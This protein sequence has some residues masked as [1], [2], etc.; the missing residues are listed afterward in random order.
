MP[1]PNAESHDALPDFGTKW[2][3]DVVGIGVVGCGN[4]SPIYLQNLSLF[5]GTKVVAVTDL[6]AAKAK[7]R[8]EE[9][10]VPVRDSVEDLVSD[11]SVEIVLNLTVPKVHFQVAALAVSAGK[12][13]YNEKPLT[14]EW[15]DGQSLVQQAKQQGVLIGCAPDTFLGAGIQTCREIVDSGRIGVPVAVQA[16]MLCPG[17]ESWHPDPGFYYEKGGGPL[18]DMGPYYLT[19]LVAL[20]GPIRTV[21]GMARASF[22]TRTITSEP[23]RGTSIT[24]ETPTNLSTVLEFGSGAIG[25]LSTSFDVPAHTLPH[26]EIYGSEGTLQVP[27]PNGFGGTPKLWTKSTGAWEDIEIVRPYSENSRGV[28]VLD[29]AQAAQNGRSARASGNLALHVLE[30]MHAAHWAAERREHVTLTTTVDRP[31]PMPSKPL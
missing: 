31:E 9:F 5:E 26:I 28:G 4:I 10:N 22:P 29:L 12:H 13:V 3:V 7:A 18:F 27:D 21:T 8:A 16:F 30:T 25:Q 6:D 15:E 17:H 23:K 2:A 20:L 24:V 14:V 11:P 1:V 19:A